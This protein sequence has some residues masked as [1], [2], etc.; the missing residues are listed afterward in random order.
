MK[1]TTLGNIAEKTQCQSVMVAYAV[2]LIAS[3]PYRLFFSLIFS[4]SRSYLPTAVF[5]VCHW[6]NLNNLTILI[7]G[8]K[9]GPIL[10]FD[11]D[12]LSEC[13]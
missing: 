4:V 3:L 10:I 2:Y 9:M 12:V 6:P 8:T 13:R 7:V 1:E 5:Y 11:C